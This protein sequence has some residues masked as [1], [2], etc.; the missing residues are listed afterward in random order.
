MSKETSWM[1][2]RPSLT[3]WGTPRNE[4]IGRNFGDILHPAWR[5]HFKENFPS[6][7][8]VGEILGV[9]FEM[10]KKDGSTIVVH[11]NG[12]I[13]QDDQGRFLRTHCIFQDITK[14]KRAEEY[15]QQVLDATNDGIWDYDLASGRFACSE[16]FAEILGYKSEEIQDFGCFCKDN[17]HPEDAERFRETFEG[18][19]HGRLPRYATEFRLKTKEGDYKWIYTR[20][21][22]LRRDAAGKATRI[23]GVHADI[24]DRKQAEE[25]LKRI[26]WMLSEKPMSS[27]E[28]TSETHDQGYGDSDRIES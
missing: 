3:S 20:G 14:Q 21:Q 11:F 24:T 2:T 27:I 10:V 19:V 25:K 18:Y 17:I 5:E 8:A 9:E 23:V 6:F 15:L 22:A 13:Q 12:K 4:L 16:R 1:S 7:K 26:E 28:L